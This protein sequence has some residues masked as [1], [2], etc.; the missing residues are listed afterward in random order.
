M[1]LRADL[2]FITYSEYLTDSKSD[3][4]GAK[5]FYNEDTCSSKN[6]N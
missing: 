2:L 3:I 6:F 4:Y 5:G 1:D